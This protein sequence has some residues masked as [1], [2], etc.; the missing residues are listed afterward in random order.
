MARLALRVALLLVVVA[1]LSVGTAGFSAVDAD[2]AIEVNVVDDDEAYV[3]V[4]ACAKGNDS[5]GSGKESVRVRVTN[6]YTDNLTVTA[7]TSVD[8]A[9]TDDATGAEGTVATGER[10]HFEVVFADDVR[11]V[12]VD[13]T[14][15]GFD[16]G[17][18]RQV[19]AKSDCPFA[20][21]TD[22]S[23]STTNTSA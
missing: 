14:A 7:I 12:T 8:A 5:T 2:R 18:T 10:D 4:V 17:V 19:V 21:D 1:G 11:Q 16:V 15:Q 22:Q 6:R 9:R 23:Q 13:V 20:S 3:G